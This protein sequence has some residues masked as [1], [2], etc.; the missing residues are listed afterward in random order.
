MRFIGFFLFL[1]FVCG[2]QAQQ[3]PSNDFRSPL[4]IPLYLS[5]TFGEC[6]S[7]HFH[8]GMDIKTN[9]K[10]GYQ[11]YS[12]GDGYVSRI[13]VSAYG[14]GNALYITHTN[15][16]TSVYGHLSKFE[17][18]IGE[19]IRQK[20][21]EN[22]SFEVDEYLYPGQIEVKKGEVV[23]LSGNTGGSAGPHLHFEIRD[24]DE[25]IINPQFFGIRVIDNIEPTIKSIVI[26]N[27]ND[28]RLS[29]T[30][31]I[32][33]V[34]KS[35]NY[36]VL[37]ETLKLN[38]FYCAFGIN[39]YDKMDGSGNTN[40]IF[41]IKL[42]QDDVLKYE[43]EMDK[44]HFDDYRYVYSYVDYALKSAGKGSYQKMF[45]DPNISFP[46][47]KI[48]ENRGICTLSNQLSQ[49]RVEVGDFNG[50]VSTLL[51]YA[52]HDANFNFFSYK[53][54]TYTQLFDPFQTN[55]FNGDHCKLKMDSD[56]LFDSLFFNYNEVS[57][58][59][60]Y[61]NVHVVGS[62]NIP[63]YRPFDLWLKLNPIGIEDVSKLLIVRKKGS[64]FDAY[65]SE[66][67]EG[68]WLSASVKSMGSFYITEDKNAPVITPINIYNGK[69]LSKENLIRFKAYDALSG[70][71]E[72]NVF[73]DNQ[74]ILM[75]HDGKAAAFT[76]D[77]SQLQ[78]T[79]ETHSLQLVMADACN[80]V[81]NFN[82]TF[83][84]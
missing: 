56:V 63:L 79:G 22:Q 58:S 84:Y 23:A 55:Y 64:G 40:G 57:G 37:A 18:S 67:V 38:T 74:W 82:C 44:F 72:Y 2:L 52:M 7:T 70:I 12:I 83:V 59:S 5:G 32:K 61:S 8:A 34:N 6:R 46:P 78:K 69:N 76:I 15:G 33:Y 28:Q 13:K 66:Y 48:I 14:Y 26:Y 3:Y 17:G 49:F 31:Q 43:Y 25:N 27:E 71:E 80:N 35:G 73:I 45:K 30:N 42:Y 24:V 29:S 16:Y 68:G 50:N 20:Q 54:I 1:L 36:Y 19:Y 21:I 51:F 81:A 47:Q 60:P 75:E 11:V 62:E 9:A 4:D 41:S 10:I 77:L 53:A 39:C 65:K